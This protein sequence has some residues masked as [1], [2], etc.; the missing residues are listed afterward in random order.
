M[1]KTLRNQN[2]PFNRLIHQICSDPEGVGMS[3]YKICQTVGVSSSQTTHQ[4]NIPIVKMI[5]HHFI[6]LSDSIHR[7][8]KTAE[9][10]RFQYIRPADIKHKIRRKMFWELPESVFYYF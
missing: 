10:I 9:P 5:E 4:R 6:P 8:R 2:S 7:K 1:R 3:F